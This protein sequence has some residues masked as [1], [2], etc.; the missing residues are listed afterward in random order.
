VETCSKDKTVKGGKVMNM[1]RIIRTTVCYLPVLMSL[2]MLGSGCATARLSTIKPVTATPSQV[3][4][5]INDH[6]AQRM[7]PEQI[8]EFKV[9]IN[10]CLR[11]GGISAVSPENKSVS[12]ISG[13]ITTYDPG[14]RALRYFIWFGAGT[15]T[16]K[17][18]WSLK[19]ENGAI[20]GSCEIDGSIS[21]GGFGGDF[22]EVIEKAGRQLVKFLNGHKE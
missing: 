11:K 2:V 14:N 20:L 4:L 10:E 15:G 7:T 6:T 12:S 8:D 16:L 3:A 17:S 1:K 5:V 21:M 13:E 9:I 22:G 18:S 19:D